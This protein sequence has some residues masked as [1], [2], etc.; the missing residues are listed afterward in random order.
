MKFENSIA[1][2]RNSSDHK[3]G[4]HYLEESPL[5]GKHTI[6]YSL[7]ARFWC[8]VLNHAIML[9]SND[10]GLLHWISVAFSVGT[11]VSAREGLYRVHS[12]NV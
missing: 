8:L 11:N 5:S 1:R 7:M 10:A 12:K 9:F 3:E 2:S 4:K 6:I